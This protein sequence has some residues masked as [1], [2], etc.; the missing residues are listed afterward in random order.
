MSGWLENAGQFGKGLGEGGWGVIK[1]TATGFVDLAKGGYQLATDPEFREQAYQA[2]LETAQTVKQGIG[3]AIDDPQAAYEGVRD[4]ASAAWDA[5]EAAEAQAAAEG[6]LAEFRGQIAGRGLSEIG[7]L[8]VPVS[9]LGKLSKLGEAVELAGDAQ[10]LEKAAE[11]EVAAVKAANGLK[12]G[13]ALSEH[14][15]SVKTKCLKDELAAKTD[16]VKANN[17]VGKNTV[18]KHSATC[19]GTQTGGCPISMV[20]GEEL[21]ERSDFSLP[22]PLTLDWTRFYRSG[23]SATNLQLG[24]GWLTPLDE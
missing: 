13:E 17:N 11:A 23:Q 6:R 16:E 10:K 9:K 14:A 7:S 2:T 20:T 1:D 5:Y 3:A 24:Y 18:D 8:L 21:L 4:R 12:A 22:G 19:S 15:P